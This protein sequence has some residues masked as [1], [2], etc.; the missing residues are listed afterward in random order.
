MA[1]NAIGA[2]ARQAG[3]QPSTLRYYE[4]IGLLHSPDRMNGQRR[5]DAE[6]LKRLSIIQIAKRAGFTLKEIGTL[7]GGL[8]DDTPPSARWKAL[9]SKKLPEVDRLISQ[10]VGMKKLLEEGMNCDCLSLDECIVCF[11]EV[12]RDNT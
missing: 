5:Y 9:A 8:S 12:D 1:E 2:V 7:L 3:I 4:S 10:A 11:D 6:A